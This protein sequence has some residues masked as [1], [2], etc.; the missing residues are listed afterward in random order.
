M[1]LTKFDISFIFYVFDQNITMGAFLINSF[2]L[3][4][5]WFQGLCMDSLVTLL[6]GHFRSVLS[7]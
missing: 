2:S 7:D 4:H 1:Y 5:L 3:E 6:A